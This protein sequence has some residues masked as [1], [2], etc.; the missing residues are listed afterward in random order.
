MHVP[1]INIKH[2]IVYHIQDIRSDLVTMCC[3]AN[4]DKICSRIMD[5]MKNL[6]ALEEKL[7]DLVYLTGDEID[8]IQIVSK[9]DE[10]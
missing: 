7:G 6:N 2:P 9:E 10:S 3:E 5:A 8:G 4:K 1:T